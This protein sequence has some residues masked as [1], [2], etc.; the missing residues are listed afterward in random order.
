MGLV[1]LIGIMY[2]GFSA[3]AV[4]LSSII[5]DIFAPTNVVWVL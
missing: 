3:I 5:I 2:F 4:L 1:Y